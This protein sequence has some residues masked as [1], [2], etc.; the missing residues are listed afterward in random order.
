MQYMHNT[1]YTQ[2]VSLSMIRPENLKVSTKKSTV[3]YATP[4]MIAMLIHIS[5][6]W[7]LNRFKIVNLLL[8]PRETNGI[9]YT[10]WVTA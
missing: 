7:I 5:L 9:I 3:A 10:N 1:A 4:S 6:L 2:E 8:S